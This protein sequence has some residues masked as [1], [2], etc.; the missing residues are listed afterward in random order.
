MFVLVLVHVYHDHMH[1]GSDIIFVCVCWDYRAL[2]ASRPVLFVDVFQKSFILRK[3]SLA[4]LGCHSMI[5][6]GIR[7]ANDNTVFP[8]SK[9]PELS[10]TDATTKRN[11]KLSRVIRLDDSQDRQ[12]ILWG[13]SC[14]QIDR[15]VNQITQC[16][17]ESSP[18]VHKNIS[19]VPSCFLR[20]PSISPYLMT[21]LYCMLSPWMYSISI[22]WRGKSGEADSASMEHCRFVFYRNYHLHY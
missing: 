4:S 7:L 10:A 11:S 3:T 17:L 6:F 1:V 19:N 21:R 12:Q 8:S 13:S 16:F 14:S 15:F 22:L 5:P 20:R 2:L 18:I 9:W